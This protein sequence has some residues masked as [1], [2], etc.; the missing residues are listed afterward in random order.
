MVVPILTLAASVLVGWIILQPQ[1]LLAATSW[2]PGASTLAAS[3]GVLAVCAGL[4]YLVFLPNYQRMLGA[5]QSSGTLTG[6]RGMLHDGFFFDRFY[7][8]LYSGIVRPISTAVS[9]IQ[10][11]LV[12]TNMGLLLLAAGVLFALF[13]IGVL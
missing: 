1:P 9:Y 8:W 13:A 7:V 3:L 5:V 4:A 11:G 6:L 12:E 10:T 2:I